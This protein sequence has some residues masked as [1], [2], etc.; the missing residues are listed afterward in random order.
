MTRLSGGL[1]D[2]RGLS[3]DLAADLRRDALAVDADPFDT[4][5]LRASGTMELLRLMSTPKAFRTG[6]VPPCAEEFTTSCLGRVVANVELA[7]GDVGVMNACAAPSLAGLAVEALGDERQQEW[8]YRDLAD[9]RSWTFFG[10]T[11]PAR[12]SD[13][14]AMLTR[15]DRAPGDAADFLLSGAKRYVANAERGTT[16]V[17]FARTGPTALS[18]R[19]VMLRHPTPGFTG[20]ALPMMGLRGACIGH[21]SFDAVPVAPDMVLGRHL[22]ASRR[23]MWGAVRAFNVIRLQIGAQA[24]GAAYAIRDYVCEQRP[25]WA[26]HAVLSARLDAARQLVYDKA[27]ETDHAPDDRR[28]PSVAKLHTTQLAVEATRWAESALGPG[29]LLDHPLLEKWCRDVYAFEFMDGTSNIL[30]LTVAPDAVP[31]GARAR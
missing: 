24:L 7:T 28:A 2:L 5:R 26:G 27:V 10:M 23:G 30:H 13:A 19:A 1:R 21:M 22:P 16:G 31:G 15:L 20:T 6:E 4:E 18:I 12:G 9:N 25:G 11:E 8:F 14:T 17:V 29:C 3:R